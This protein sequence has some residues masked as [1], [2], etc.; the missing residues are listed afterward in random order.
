MNKLKGE[1]VVFNEKMAKVVFNRTSAPII[2][3]K[4]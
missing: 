3:Q 1:I 4:A 2:M